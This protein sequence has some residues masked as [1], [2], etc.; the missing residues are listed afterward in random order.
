LELDTRKGF[1]QPLWPDYVPAGAV[2]GK[3]ITSDLAQHM[4]FWARMGHPC[5]D[6]FE[7]KPFLAAHPEFN[8]QSPYLVDMPGHEWAL[9]ASK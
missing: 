3:V 6:S 5:G 7:A 1:Y 9:F 4:S 2:Q 8:W